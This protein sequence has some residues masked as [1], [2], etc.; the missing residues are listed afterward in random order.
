MAVTPCCLL[1]HLEKIADP[2]SA[3]PV[4]GYTRP[5]HDGGLNRL[6]NETGFHHL[7]D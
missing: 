4:E 5:P 7:P 6:T 1:L 3:L 2:L